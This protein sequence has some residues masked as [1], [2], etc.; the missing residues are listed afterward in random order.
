MPKLVPVSLDKFSTRRWVRYLDYSFAAWDV[1]AFI[2]AHEAIKALLGMPL[3]FIL[4]NGNYRLIT[5]QGLESQIN[6]FVNPNKKWRGLYIPHCYL[7]YPFYLIE[8]E[9]NESV[10]CVD[11]DS[12]LIKDDGLRANEAFFG[13]DGKPAASVSEVLGFLSNHNAEMESTIKSCA[14]LQELRLIKP[15]LLKVKSA[16][17]DIQLEGVFCI[18]EE[19]LNSLSASSLKELHKSNALALAYAQLFSMQNIK[20]LVQALDSDFSQ[21]SK[22]TKPMAPEINFGTMNTDGLLNFDNL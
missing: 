21:M 4:R 18:D 10:L 14:L 2:T 5:L 3:A 6:L 20:L 16:K 13:E 9:R 7:C 19:R 1:F 22:N 12:G 8:N 11:E 15:W 17:G